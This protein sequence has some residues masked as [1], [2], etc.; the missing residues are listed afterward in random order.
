MI[1][2]NCCPYCGCIDIAIDEIERDW[3]SEEDCIVAY[4]GKCWECG[5]EFLIS[6][7]VSVTSR[8][9]A[10]DDKELNDLIKQELDEGA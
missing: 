8:I 1:M 3:T 5:K 2:D 7:V 4:N 9:V 6:E 10:K